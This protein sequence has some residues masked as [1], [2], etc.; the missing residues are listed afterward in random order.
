MERL[1]KRIPMNRKVS[2]TKHR[3]SG[4]DELQEGPARRKGKER[5]SE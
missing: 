4:G 3:A 1:S 5:V 2:E